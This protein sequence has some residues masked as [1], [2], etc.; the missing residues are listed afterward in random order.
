MR[1][2]PSSPETLGLPCVSLITAKAKGVSS[3]TAVLKV[4]GSLK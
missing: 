2:L 3:F 1:V 4:A